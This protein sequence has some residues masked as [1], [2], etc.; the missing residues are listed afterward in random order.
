MRKYLAL[1]EQENSTAERQESSKH[2][3]HKSTQTNRIGGQR[4]KSKEQRG[5]SGY[6][7]TVIV[8]LIVNVSIWKEENN[9]VS[10]FLLAIERPVTWATQF[11]IQKIARVL[12]EGALAFLAV[13]RAVSFC[14]REV[15]GTRIRSR[16]SF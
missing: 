11:F 13:I 12:E 3:P 7:I 9:V 8:L 6:I 5:L 16:S 4:Y 15:D 14:L 1:L 2:G 10:C